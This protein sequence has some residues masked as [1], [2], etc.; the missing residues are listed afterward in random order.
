[1]PDAKS[2]LFTTSCLLMPAL[3]LIC[4]YSQ[5]RNISRDHTL[6][7]WKPKNQFLRGPKLFGFPSVFCFP[8]EIRKTHRVFW[9][10]SVFLVFLVRFLVKN[11]KPMC[12]LISVGKPK[13]QCVFFGFLLENQKTLGKRKIQKFRAPQK[14]LGF[15]IFGSLSLRA[16]T[17]R[18]MLDRKWL[19]CASTCNKSLTRKPQRSKT[20]AWTYNTPSF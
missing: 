7:R 1:M 4:L 16:N 14:S 3:I 18:S 20:L 9:I 11:K 12:F 17:A 10:L 13:Q 15:C 5:A 19:R 6:R 2:C 8:T